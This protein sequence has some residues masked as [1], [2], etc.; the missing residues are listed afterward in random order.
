MIGRPR[1]SRQQLMSHIDVE[2]ADVVIIDAAVSVAFIAVE[3]FAV[4]FVDDDDVINDDFNK[5]IFWC[6]LRMFIF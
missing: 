5:T 4:A 1:N 2:R 6:S 3:S